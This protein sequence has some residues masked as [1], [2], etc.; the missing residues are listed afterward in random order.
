MLLPLPLLSVP[1]PAATLLVSTVLPVYTFLVALVVVIIVVLLLTV[2]IGIISLISGCAA[3][4]QLS[5][6]SPSSQ[7]SCGSE[8]L[9]FVRGSAHHGRTIFEV[10]SVFVLPPLATMMLMMVMVV[11]VAGSGGSDDTAI[12]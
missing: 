11:I 10:A 4:L 2:S 7:T 5:C 9:R 3:L 12:M 8:S 6:S 1:L